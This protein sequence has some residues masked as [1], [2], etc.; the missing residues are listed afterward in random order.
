[1][2][3]ASKSIKKPEIWGGLECSFNRV[4]NLYMDQLLYCGHYWRTVE[5]IDRIAALGIKAMRY[6]II[7]ER[8]LPSPQHTVDWSSAETALEALRKNKINPI[9]GLVHHGS[10][11]DY[12]GIL[13]AE[14]P[15][16][17]SKFAKEVAMKFPWI[18]CYTPV[19]E[20]LTTARFCGLYGLWFPHRRSDRAFVLALL[21]ELKAIVL[22]MREIR[23]INPAA[24]LL[25][26]EDLAKIYSTPHLSYQA[27]FENYRRWLTFDF[28]CG[29][30]NP[31]HPLWDYFLQSGATESALYFF[32]ENPCPPDVLGLDYYA[33]SERSLD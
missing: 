26:T 13:D 25:Q 30:M 28:L 22:S 21:N 31:E 14:F 23:K 15:S 29:K 18:E 5:D 6:P 16:G 19:N 7:W 32:T 8:L 3:M 1:M 9:A 20:P 24:R 12:A 17:L 10:G 33:T 11:P 27:R 2:L 4:K